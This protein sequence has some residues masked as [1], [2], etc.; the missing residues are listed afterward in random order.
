MRQT[1]L[2]SLVRAAV[3]TRQ[4]AEHYEL[5][6]SRSGITCYPVHHDK[7]P[8]MKVDE[9]YYCFG[10]HQTG[11][12]IHLTAGLFHTCLLDNPLE[13]DYFHDN[14]QGEVNRIHDKTTEYQSSSRNAVCS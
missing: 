8:S 1:N 6:I 9:R 2:F 10:C 4:A 12:V 14:Y 5:R 11:D 7:H 3:T 13:C